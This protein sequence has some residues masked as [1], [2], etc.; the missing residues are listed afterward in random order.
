MPA[1]LR[2]FCLILSQD[3]QA[4]YCIA[5]KGQQATAGPAAA[6]K[7]KPGKQGDENCPIA[8]VVHWLLF[9]SYVCCLAHCLPAPSQD[10]QV[11]CCTALKERVIAS[12]AAAGKGKP[13]KQGDANF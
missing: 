6:G 2:I 1:D 3:G 13:G 7:G 5:L 4:L 11:L 9:A 10:G 12:L 8:V